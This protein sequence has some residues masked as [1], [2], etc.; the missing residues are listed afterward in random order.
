MRRPL[1]VLVVCGCLVGVAHA[2]GRPSEEAVRRNQRGVTYQ[3]QG[4][5]EEALAEFRQAAQMDPGNIAVLMNLAHAYGLQGRIDEAIAEYRKVLQRQPANALAQNNLGA[6]YD[7]KGLHDEAIREFEQI[8]QRDASNASAM[9][10]V[11]TAKRNR[12]T[13]Q[14]R[15][16][17]INRA[18]KEADARPRD[19]RAAYTVARL[20]AI[21][22][23]SEEALTWLTRA[24][25]LGLDNVEYLTVDPALVR[26]R[27]DPRFP[28]LVER[29]PGQS[30]QPR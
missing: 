19:A 8:L 4:K 16:N 22:G 6:L 23:Q 24:V 17:E 12:A 11:E 27:D 2:Q 7:R 18:V 30:G 20:H 15:D 10:N 28:K 29:R 1:A 14:G 21:H 5:L 13:V 3:Q 25:D 26:L 9:K